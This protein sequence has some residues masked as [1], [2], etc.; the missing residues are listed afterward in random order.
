MSTTQIRHAVADDAETILH[1]I[2]QLA[3]YEKAEDQVVCSVDDIV[4]DGFGDSPLFNCLLADYDG[5]TV[6]MALFFYNWSTWTGRPTLY[7]EDLFVMPS[8]RGKGLGLALLQRCACIAVE[9]QCQRFEWAV[10]DWNEPARNFYHNIGAYHKHEWL[11]YRLEGEA[12]TALA[13]QCQ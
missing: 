11:P 13:A 1:L 9:K 10:L 8:H 5:Q 3:R 2:H 12:L 7:L 4:R 6:G